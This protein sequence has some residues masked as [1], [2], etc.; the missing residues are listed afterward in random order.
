MTV[1]AHVIDDQLRYHGPNVDNAAHIHRVL[2]WSR[3][4]CFIAT[5]VILALFLAGYLIFVAGMAASGRADLDLIGVGVGSGRIPHDI[6][7]SE[8]GLDALGWLLY[9]AKTFVT[10][11][12]AFLP[13]LGAAI[14]GIQET[15]DFEGLALRSAKTANALGEID[16][17]I[18]KILNQPTLDTTAA[19]LL[20][21]AEVLTEDLG[22]WQSI[23]GRKHL[24]LP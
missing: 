23:Y 7:H 19:A 16:G 15:G 17:Q 14:A 6:T 18:A 13:A 4:A 24:G 22:A 21:T 2:K 11:F 3:D 9:R 5:F 8:S 10:F 12:A 20:S 1:R